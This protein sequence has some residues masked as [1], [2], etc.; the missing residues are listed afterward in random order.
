MPGHGTNVINVNSTLN[1]ITTNVNG[2]GGARHD[3]RQRHRHRRHAERG[4]RHAAGGSTVNVVADSEPVNVTTNGTSPAFDTVNIGAAGGTG[5]LPGITGLVTVTGNQPYVAG[6]Q[7][8][9]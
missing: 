2:D 7:R 8:P 6:H 4:H 1:G 5:N 3:Q 9:G